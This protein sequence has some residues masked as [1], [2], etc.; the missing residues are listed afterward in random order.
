MA[1][2]TPVQAST[3]LAYDKNSNVVTRTDERGHPW[4]S[5]YT[6]RDRVL[7]S[8]DPLTN[9]TR[10][11]YTADTLTAT[12]TNANSHTTTYAYDACCACNR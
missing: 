7:T 1:L 5:T 11:T 10:Y 12:V 8:A 9:T 4:P 3:T 6:V 2:G